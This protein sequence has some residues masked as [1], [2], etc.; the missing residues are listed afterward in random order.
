MAVQ[1]LQLKGTIRELTQNKLYVKNLLIMTFVWSFG[2]FGFFLMPFYLGT[3]PGNTFEFAIFSG[4]A[5]LLTSLACVMITKFFTLKQSMLIF[6]LISC[7]GSLFLIIF[8]DS[9][10]IAKAMI[11]M[12]TNFGVT[13]AFD[14][15]YM[16]NV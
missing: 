4:T 15:A 6:L 11:I 2:S 8:F 9:P 5:E 16:L 10:D 3:I 12:L 1:D 7:V 13:G 14:I